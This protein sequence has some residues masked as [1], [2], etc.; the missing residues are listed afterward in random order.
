MATL[1]P[2]SQQSPS[3]FARFRRDTGSGPGCRSAA[4][5]LLACLV[6]P[7]QKTHSYIYRTEIER[8]VL[9]DSVYT[10]RYFFI[11]GPPGTARGVFFPVMV[12]NVDEIIRKYRRH[13]LEVI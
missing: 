4:A 1:N 3:Y 13:E 8:I 11:Y 5:L 6:L 9:V 12:T 2:P 10:I 7:V